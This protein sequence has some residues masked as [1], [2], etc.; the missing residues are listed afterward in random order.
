MKTLKRVKSLLFMTFA[1][2]AIVLAVNASS[3]ARG[4]GGHGFEGGHDGG[5]GAHQG[6]HAAVFL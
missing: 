6:L 1:A 2:L 5:S 3:E 4:T